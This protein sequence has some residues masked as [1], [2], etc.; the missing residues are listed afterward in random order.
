MRTFIFISIALFTFTV[1]EAQQ[2]EN[3]APE[4]KTK[5][6]ETPQGNWTVHKKYDAQGNLIAKDSTYSYSWSS[7][8]GKEVPPQKAQQ[9]LQQMKQHMQRFSQADFFNHMPNIDSLQQAFFGNSGFDISQIQQQMSQ[10]MQALRHQFSQQR[11]QSQRF[12]PRE[13]QQSSS[14]DSTQSASQFNT[15]RI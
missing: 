9:L 15:T 11:G 2:R 4:V 12:I 6:V 3:A 7:I 13:S 1:A 8:N 5:T 14:R 10:Q